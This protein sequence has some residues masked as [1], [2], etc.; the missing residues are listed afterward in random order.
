M[1]TSSNPALEPLAEPAQPAAQPFTYVDA[2]ALAAPPAGGR[3]PAENPEDFLHREAAA[4][5]AGL[6]EGEARART[7]FDQRL[8]EVRQKLDAALRDFA[9]ERSRYFEQV[10]PEVVQLALAIARRILHREAQ[11]DPLLLAGMVRVAL[12]KIE[13]GAKVVVRVNPQQ[14]SECRTYFASHLEGREIPE[15]EDDPAIEKDTCTLH[16]ALGTV[17]LGLEV[18]LKEIE[19]GLLDVLAQ[20]PQT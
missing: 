7:G 13:Q 15:V 18:Q 20:K 10:E 2:V 12:E 17:E 5:T 1:S 16:T 8:A 14:V 9:R 19:R 4:R 6:L 3:S 11:I